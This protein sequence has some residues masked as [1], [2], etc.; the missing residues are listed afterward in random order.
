MRRSANSPALCLTS[1]PSALRPGFLTQRVQRLAERTQ[2]SG[3]AASEEEVSHGTGALQGGRCHINA[4]FRQLSC[5]LLNLCALCVET[6]FFNAE[7]AE[8]SGENAKKRKSRERGRSQPRDGR[9]PGRALPHK[10]GVP[11][12]LLPSA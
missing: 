11:P 9:T 4:A 3:R 7:G 1:A 5:P 12:T 6:R 10:C 8:V 2:R